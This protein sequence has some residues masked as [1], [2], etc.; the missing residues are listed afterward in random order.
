M[1]SINIK[2]H[3]FIGINVKNAKKGGEMIEIP[4]EAWVKVSGFKEELDEFFRWLISYCISHCVRKT[5]KIAYRVQLEK[6]LDKDVSPFILTHYDD[7]ISSDIGQI[8]LEFDTTSTDPCIRQV[9][10]DLEYILL[11]LP[12]KTLERRFYFIQRG[13]KAYSRAMSLGRE[14][15]LS[16]IMEIFKDP[17]HWCVFRNWKSPHDEYY[18]D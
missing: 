7:I 10:E 17:D 14:D 1:N 2:F 18:V 6:Q 8:S 15:D 9:L 3:P 11:Q 12:F 13:C 16:T 5:G 4:Y